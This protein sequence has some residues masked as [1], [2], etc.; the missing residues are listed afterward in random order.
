MASPT[1]RASHR[2]RRRLHRPLRW[3]EQIVLQL[4]HALPPVPG[5]VAPS[6]ARAGAT[7][8]TFL[9]WNI[10]AM[11]GTVR[12]VLRQA[13]GL[14]AQ[15]HPVRIVAV[16]CHSY[17]ERPFFEVPDGVEVEVLVDRYRL[18]RRRGPLAVFARWI[19]R[20]PSVLR[21]LAH[22]R[23]TQ[24][25][26]LTD[27]RTVTRIARTRGIVMGTRYGLTVSL[28]RFAHP[29]AITV[30]QEHLSIDRL[31][32][33]RLRAAR[34]WYP[35]LDLV[36]CLTEAERASYRR[37]LK[38]RSCPPTVVLPNALPDRLPD[39][40]P[41]DQR[42]RRVISIGRLDTD[43]NHAD[44]IEAFLA[45][46]EDQPGWELTLVGEG[47]GRRALEELVERRGATD[48]VHFPGASDD[49]DSELREASVF[50][51][52]SSFE[53][54]GLVLLEAMA[55]G[56]PLL[57]YAAPKGPRELLTDG[58]DALLVPVGD[59]EGLTEGLR[60][61]LTDDRLRHQLGQGG[62]RT[63]ERYRNNEVCARWVRL[64]DDLVR[65][66][67]DAAA[68]VAAADRAVGSFSPVDVSEDHL[69]DG[70]QRHQRVDPDAAHREGDL[71]Q[72]G[73]P[74]A[75]RPM[76]SASLAT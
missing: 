73:E 21:S 26:L 42:P 58:E 29:A 51:S 34:R 17:Q 37:R 36:A 12:T 68:G 32:G 69:E 46:T 7:P 18:K 64:L 23:T 6:A 43:K 28:A 24:A 38:K 2:L 74:E 60:L 67:G 56:L 71:Q 31:R 33:E 47:R 5:P 62:R 25:S 3:L 70:E 1:A 10:H 52:S 63:A 20:R 65:A 49:V 13:E 14:V 30:G 27:V 4:L 50:I 11:G 9:I 61:L 19:D 54:F 44:A 75:G 48:R 45:A 76:S 8:V 16:L 40:P 39:L 15:G 35:R 53:S 41:D 59:V 57:A 72:R 22:G 55:A 66:R